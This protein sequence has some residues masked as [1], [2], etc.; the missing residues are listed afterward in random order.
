[1]FEHI[2]V[3]LDGSPL[4]ECVVPHAVAMAQT[5]DARITLLHVL[6]EHHDHVRESSSV[7][8][9]DWRLW[10]A[11]G[12]AYLDEM[13]A[14]MHEVGL[15]TEQVLLEGQAA[16]RIVEFTHEQDVDLIILSSHGWSGL[17]PWNVGSVVQKI[18]LQTH[19]SAMIVRAYEL[20]SEDLTGLRYR[21]LLVP[22]D[23][24]S[25]AEVV[26]APLSTL[27]LFH[28]ARVFLAHVVSTPDMLTREPLS[29][30]DVELVALIVERNREAAAQYLAQLKS[31]LDVNAETR[32]FVSDSTE[33]T[34]HECVDQEGVDLVVISAH[35]HSGEARR[36]YGSM[37]MSFVV[38]GTSPLLIVQDLPSNEMIPTRAELAIQEY[39]GH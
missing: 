34:L 32:L 17:S 20:P 7:N 39:K 9:M 18:I 5:F 14:R 27:A 16:E 22:L 31:R 37:T 28:G 11:E 8:L 26:L 24:S 10:K 13:A 36:P 6:E 4:A 29:E 33:A 15:R 19:T 2:L 12:E 35:G 23:G 38:N 30:E 3:P 1:M 21:G 25:R